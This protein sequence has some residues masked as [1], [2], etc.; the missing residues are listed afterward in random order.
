MSG[1]RLQDARRA[2]WA[3]AWVPLIGEHAIDFVSARVRNYQS[4]PYWGVIADQLWLR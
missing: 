2:E 1:N 4:Q 3:S